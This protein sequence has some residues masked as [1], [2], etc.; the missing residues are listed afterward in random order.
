[1]KES[2]K[3]RKIVLMGMMMAA[4]AA[5]AANVMDIDDTSWW[6]LSGGVLTL[7]NADPDISA[8]T[9]IY[10]AVIGADVT[11]IVKTGPGAVRLSGNNPNFAGEIDVQAGI[12]M[13]WVREKT[14][15]TYTEDNYGH[16]SQVTVADGGA[17]DG[18]K[19]VVVTVADPSAPAPTYDNTW[20]NTSGGSWSVAAN[21][22]DA[23][24]G[25]PNGSGKTATFNP[26]TKA[27]VGVTLDETVTLGGLTF[28]AASN[29]KYGYTLSGQGLTLDNGVGTATVANAKGTNTIA[30][31]VTLATDAE[32]QTAAGNELRLTGGVSGDKDLAVNTHVTTGAGQVNLHVSPNYAGKI[33]T[34]SGRVVMD[35]LSFVQSA[36]QLTLGIGTFLYT[37]PDAEIPGFSI[38]AGSSRP[39]V[40]ESDSDVT[41]SEIGV[42]TSAF[43]KLGSGTLTLH[44]TGTFSPNV[45][46]DY[47]GTA[48]NRRVA[49]NGDG[50]PTTF[51]DINISNGAFVQGE[52]GD[53]ANAPTVS[54]PQLTVGAYT[55]KG[56]STYVL[57]NGLLSV[58]STIWLGYYAPNGNNYMLTLRQNGGTLTCGSNFQ[59]GYENNKWG[60]HNGVSSCYEMNGGTASFAGSLYM[61]RNWAR[62]PDKQ[63]CRFVQNGGEVSV[64]GD[65]HLAYAANT[66]KGY[67]D[68]NGGV[69][70]V[71]GTFYAANGTNNVTELRLNP[72]GTFRCNV[73]GGA[74]STS[75]ARFYA[76]GGEF[77]PLGLAAA[78]LEMPSDAFTSLYASTNGLVV[79]TEE[80]SAGNAYTLNQAVLHDPALDAAADG[81]LVKRGAGLLTLAGANTYTGMTAVEGGILALSGAGTLGTGA[82]LAVADGAIC[83]LGGTEQAAEAV[84]A[85]GL[86]RNGALTVTEALRV[87]G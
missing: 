73:I 57:N 75:T 50:P 32:L 86:V 18:M 21:W 64:A 83:D 10:T 30:S 40:F 20:T 2:Q 85:S 69:F 8:S 48:D 39:A 79:N 1:M 77:R 33:T 56:P 15:S 13:G 74:K 26:A 7:N 28:T 5:F 22:E 78:A 87:G 51:R 82:G 44:G 35:D 43:L 72:G 45:R 9:N 55:L 16:P 62:W 46:V 70:T 19:A 24:S 67:M 61:G 3:M 29:A 65:A 23:A 37:G 81:G 17:Y 4:G 76:N 36:D 66:E 49:A 47:N 41:V 68:L 14:G 11:K 27:G 54:A 42:G 38:N 6:S 58:S 52:V 25:A 31:A 80:L 34:G 71:N 12:L 60:N 53:D 84:A 59:W 63:V